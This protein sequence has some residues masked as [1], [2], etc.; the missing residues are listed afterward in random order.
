MNCKYC[1]HELEEDNLICPNCGKNNAEEKYF[2]S[3]FTSEK[4]SAIIKV[5]Q[6]C[7]RL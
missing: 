7:Q 5:T 3:L 4:F 2:V 1:Q 6:N